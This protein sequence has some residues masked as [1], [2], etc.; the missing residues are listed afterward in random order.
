MYH[1]TRCMQSAAPD[2]VKVGILGTGWGVRVQIPQFRIAGLNVT[3]LYSRDGQRAAELATQHNLQ[4][5]S[6]AHALMHSPDGTHVWCLTEHVMPTHP[7]HL[8]SHDPS[9]VQVVS[10]V[11][12]P[13][14]HCQQCIGAGVLPTTTHSC[15]QDTS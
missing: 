11:T 3:A 4:G 14:L 8:H 12:P 6:D 2:A 13:Y 7:Y 9:T 1:T 5:L 15:L 10:V